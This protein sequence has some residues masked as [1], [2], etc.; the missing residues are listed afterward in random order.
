M[1]KPL[2][3]HR[4]ALSRR[5][6][7]QKGLG[8]LVSVKDGLDF[9]PILGGKN[10]SVRRRIPPFVGGRMSKERGQGLVKRTLVL[11]GGGWAD[12]SIQKKQPTS[13]A[14]E[15]K[16]I[17]PTAEPPPAKAPIPYLFLGVIIVVLLVPIWIA[18][19]VSVIIKETS[20]VKDFFE[21]A[22]DLSLLVA[23]AYVGTVAAKG[24]SK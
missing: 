19:I 5:S 1:T 6:L 20:F 10:L 15:A 8:D 4:N 3:T 9:V 16:G 2:E 13:L 17:E 12:P 7:W 22:K 21:L 18:I 14:N 11:I 23:G 24:G